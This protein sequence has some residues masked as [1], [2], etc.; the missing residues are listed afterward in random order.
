MKKLSIQSILVPTDFSKMSIQFIQ[1]VSRG[2]DWNRLH[3]ECINARRLAKILFHRNVAATRL[4]QGRL[5]PGRRT[6]SGERMT[7]AA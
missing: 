4:R 1:T 3:R 6:K 7:M 2:G 5:L